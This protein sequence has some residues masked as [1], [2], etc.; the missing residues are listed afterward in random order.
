[1]SRGARGTYELKGKT[2]IGSWKGAEIFKF[3]ILSLSKNR[4]EIVI[5]GLPNNT[6]A[7]VICED[8]SKPL[9]QIM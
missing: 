5:L 3:E 4:M 1:M 9:I 7:R 6:K 2:V 8:S